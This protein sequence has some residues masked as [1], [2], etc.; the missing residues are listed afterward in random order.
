VLLLQQL[1]VLVLGDLGS[2][3]RRIFFYV[4]A[5]N[6]HFVFGLVKKLRL[7][8]PDVLHAH[9]LAY[10]PVVLFPSQALDVVKGR[11]ILPVL[12]PE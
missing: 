2:V 3:L 7:V 11:T 12:R 8:V 6:R 10:L 5:K 1:L 4:L 9:T